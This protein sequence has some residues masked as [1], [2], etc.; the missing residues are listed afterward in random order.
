MSG[1]P[2][3]R[4][5][6]HSN[7]EKTHLPPEMGTPR[8]DQMQG[9]YLDQLVELCGRV[10][11]DDRTELLTRSGW[12]RFSN[13]SR[14]EPVATFNRDTRLMEYQEPTDYI[15]K[16]Y[17]GL[18]YEVENRGVSI[19]VTS[20]H[21]LWVSRGLRSREWVLCRASELRGSPYMVE[22]SATYNGN[23]DWPGLSLPE[24]VYRSGAG[25]CF[26]KTSSGIAIL[27]ALGMAWARFLGYYFSEGCLNKAD[28]KSGRRITIYQRPETAA[29][30]IE[31]ILTLGLKLRTWMDNR[32]GV[33]RYMISSGPL[34]RYL[35][36]FGRRAADKHLPR[37]CFDWPLAMRDALLEALMHG[38]GHI[39]K[40]GV[41]VYSTRSEQLAD[42]VQQLIIMGGRTGTVSYTPS[43]RMYRVCESAH[44]ATSVNKHRPHDSLTASREIVYCVAIPNRILVTRRNKKVV[45]CGNCYDSVGK[46]DSRSSELYHRHIREVAHLSVMRHANLTFSFDC[47]RQGLTPDLILGALIGRPGAR[48]TDWSHDS[49]RFTCNM[50]AAYEWHD[51]DLV[52]GAAQEVADSLGDLVRG[53]F[54]RRAPLAMGPIDEITDHD[55]RI[56]PHLAPVGASHETEVY[57]S[58]FYSGVSRVAFSQELLRHTRECAP[59]QRSGRYVDDRTTPWVQHPLLRDGVG[60]DYEYCRQQFEMAQM[61]ARSTYMTLFGALFQMFQNAGLSKRDARKQ[62][63][64]AARGTLGQATG[65]E[66]VFT[67]PLDQWVR[68]FGQ[69]CR[70]EADGEIREVMEQTRAILAQLWPSS[71]PL[72]PLTA[73]IPPSPQPRESAP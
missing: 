6:L 20:D 3:V 13:L 29:P 28:T 4:L 43:G 48:L 11:Y 61:R 58:F 40:H 46:E 41:R 66:L 37:E 17:S 45:L 49:V 22:R 54:A 26:T 56:I 9:T 15:T 50:Q 72:G 65:T 55:R 39:T 38:D 19:R 70:P 27:P 8:H 25:G 18:M 21:E 16:E 33:M 10:C 42:D 2:V 67:A 44:G 73:T 71:F 31:C 59:S 30:I 23:S 57:A 63:R 47:F 5:V 1:K 68:I 14:G 36:Q 34:S 64:S 53:Y 35:D 24:L 7:E 32:N 52:Y 12:V 62:A 51:H 69:R 60:N